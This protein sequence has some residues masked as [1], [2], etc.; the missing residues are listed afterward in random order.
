[1]RGSTLFTDILP[2]RPAGRQIP[3]PDQTGV[4]SQGRSVERGQQRGSAGCVRDSAQQ[5]SR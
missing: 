2:Q 4:P 1:M 5:H 3:V